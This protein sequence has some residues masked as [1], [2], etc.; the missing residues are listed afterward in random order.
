MS[1]LENQEVH[2]PDYMVRSM[3]AYLEISIDEAL[4]SENPFIKALVMIDRRVGNRAIEKI[5]LEE[6][7]HTLV[8]S[9][10]DLR[11]GTRHV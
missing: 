11:R 9:F 4:Q 5:K 3:R 1:W 10:Y 8:K 7:E 6:S 2:S